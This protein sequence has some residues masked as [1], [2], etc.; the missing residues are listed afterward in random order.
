MRLQSLIILLVIVLVPHQ[1]LFAVSLQTTSSDEER[2]F[3]TAQGI[4]NDGLYQLA[5]DQLRDFLTTYPSGTRAAQ[6]QFLLGESYFHLKNY[7]QAIAEFRSLLTKYPAVKFRDKAYFR[8]G[9]AQFH[10]RQYRE[11]EKTL[12]S[13]L[14]QYPG[15][16]LTDRVYYWLAEAE[17]KQGKLNEAKNILRK[18]QTGPRKAEALIPLAS[19]LIKEGKYQEAKN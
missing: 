1:F 5:V 10:S 15:S 4:Y 2:A 9:E 14:A 6:A 8:I 19:I 11:A 3:I 16:P 18:V 17:Y 12:T 13:F 7:P